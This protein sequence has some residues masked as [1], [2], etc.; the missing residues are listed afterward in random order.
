MTTLVTLVNGGEQKHHI[1]KELVLARPLADI[2]DSFNNDLINDL[3]S[4]PVDQNNPLIDYES[5]ILEL[6]FNRLKHLNASNNIVQPGFRRLF[7]ASLVHQNESFH[8]SL[9]LCA[10][11]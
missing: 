4:V 1:L 2:V 11:V 6:N 7:I 5:L 9:N 10:H 8:A 3:T